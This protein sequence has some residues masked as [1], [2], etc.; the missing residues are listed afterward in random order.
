MSFCVAWSAL[1]LAPSV[2][3]MDLEL[4]IMGSNRERN[5]TATPLLNKADTI[6]ELRPRF[7]LT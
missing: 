6:T 2:L 5:L 7:D 3:L 4:V 1:D